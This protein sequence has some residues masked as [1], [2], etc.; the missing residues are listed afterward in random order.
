M[1]ILSRIR[2]WFSKFDL[3]QFLPVLTSKDGIDFE[4]AER[5]DIQDLLAIERDVYA[6]TVPWTYTHFVREIE[7]NPNAVFLVAKKSNHTVGFI[8]LRVML[9]AKELHVTNLAVKTSMQ[10]QG[11]GDSLLQQ[12]VRVAANL[13]LGKIT[14]ETP[15]VTDGAQGFYRKEGFESTQILASYYDDGRDAVTME[16]KL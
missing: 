6:G 9:Y 12:A 10:Q 13:N 11:I 15:R 4:M 8:G 5:S 3:R 2:T 16:K 7:N 14:L 1:A